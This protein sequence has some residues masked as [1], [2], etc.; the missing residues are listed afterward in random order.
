MATRKWVWIPCCICGGTG[1]VQGINR[2]RANGFTTW[3][4][5]QDECTNCDGE[6]GHRMPV[7]APDP[8]VMTP[9]NPWPESD[10]AYD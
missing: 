1:E 3:E 5:F 8:D 10:P 9:K 6:K 2:T 7:F 4:P